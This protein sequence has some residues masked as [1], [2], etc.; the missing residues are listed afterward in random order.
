[1]DRRCLRSPDDVK[2][3]RLMRVA[4]KAFHFEI[5]IARVERVTQ[6]RGRLGRSLKAERRRIFVVL[7]KAAPIGHYDGPAP[8]LDIGSLIL[9]DAPP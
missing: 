8:S 1:M 6:C 7:L 4:T 3:H 2:R 9:N 5:V